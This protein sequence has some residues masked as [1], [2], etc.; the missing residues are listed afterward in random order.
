MYRQICTHEDL[1]AELSAV[2]AGS[3]REKAILAIEYDAAHDLIAFSDGGEHTAVGELRTLSIDWE[4]DLEGFT[5]CTFD[6][7]ELRRDLP[8]LSGLSAIGSVRY[9][10]HVLT[11]KGKKAS[12]QSLLDELLEHS[13]PQQARFASPGRSDLDPFRSVAEEARTSA[14]LIKLLASRGHHRE[15]QEYYSLL[16]KAQIAIGQMMQTGLFLDWSAFDEA[17][18]A[19][20]SETAAYVHARD[21]Q[22][23]LR[24]WFSPCGTVTGRLSCSAPNL[25]GFPNDLKHCVI[26]P[27]GRV[28]VDADFKQSE[29]RIAA[30]LAGDKSMIDALASGK[31]IHRETASCISGVNA[32]GVTHEQRQ[33]GKAVNFGFLFG[34]TGKGLA[35]SLASIGIVKTQE[36][37]KAMQGEFA[38]HYPV[39]TAWKEQLIR[40]CRVPDRN[41]DS[42]PPT[43]VRTAMGRRI[44]V[45]TLDYRFGSKVVNYAVQGSGAELT[46]QVLGLLPE[47]LVGLDA[48]IIHCIHDEFLLEAAEDDAEQ[49]ATILAQTMTD[50]FTQLFPGAP[51][52]HLL[53]CG[54][55]KTWAEAK[56]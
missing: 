53:D 44:P 25:H 34:Q 20:R 14:R 39:L 29:M 8:D 54:I 16:R 32:D 43:G 15:H 48:K 40:G 17:G 31:D 4:Q 49:A 18:G 21:D 2:R 30:Q 42:F 37:C 9:L 33:I 52:G 1:M 38:R 22:G 55:G 5:R 27:E 10:Y 24:A 46:L 19:E 3:S 13:M 11:G 6:P 50:A 35:A 56:A 45:Y 51:T 12:L 41:S 7:A 23:R 47:R 36:E 28:L 26:A